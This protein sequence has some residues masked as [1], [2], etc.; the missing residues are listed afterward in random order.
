MLTGFQM[1]IPWTYRHSSKEFSAFLNDAKERMNLVSDNSTYTA[2]DAVFQVFRKRLS[3][4]QGLAFAGVLPSV[5]RAI[6][7]KD[8]NVSQE[9]ALFL[10]RAEMTKE[11]QL[12]RRHHSLTPDNAIEATAWALR[13]SMDQRDLDKVLASLPDG[14]RDFWHVDVRDPSE[15]EQ[16][17]I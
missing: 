13:R 10:A 4:E 1:P 11:A 7:V 8:W 9:P 16:R 17:I 14:A 3:A 5:L 6:F 12:V 2:V 15:L